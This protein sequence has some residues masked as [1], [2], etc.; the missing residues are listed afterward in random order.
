[1]ERIS[2]NADS[3]FLIMLL[4]EWG[5]VWQLVGLRRGSS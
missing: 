4:R 2:I 3:S 5:V 1:M